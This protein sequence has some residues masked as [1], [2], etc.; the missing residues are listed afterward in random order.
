MN[1]LFP[2]HR[3]LCAAENTSHNMHNIVTLRGALVRDALGV[4]EVPERD[5]RAL[6]C[7]HRRAVRAAP[8]ADVGRRRTS[9]SSSGCSATCTGTCTTRP[10]VSSTRAG[11]A[12]RSPRRSSCPP[13]SPTRGTAGATTAASSHNVKAIAQRYLGWFDGNP[14]RLHALPPE[15][16]AVRYVEYMG[17]ADT[18]LERARVAFDDGEYRWVAQVVDHVVFADPDHTR[19]ASAAGGCA[20]AARLPDR[21]RDV[22]ELLP[23]GR[24][25]AA[26]RRA[27]P[28]RRCGRPARARSAWSR[29]ST[30]WA[31]GSTARRP[32]KAVARRQLG[33]H[34]Y[35]RA[36]RRVGRARRDQLRARPPRPARRRHDH[37]GTAPCSTGSSPARSRSPD[38]LAAGDIVA[39]RRPRGTRVVLRAHRGVDTRLPDRHA[40]SLV[41]FA[42]PAR[43]LTDARAAVGVRRLRCVS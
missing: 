21:E 26:P 43:S 1:F 13:S 39:R 16:A 24:A 35:R 4:V 23:D 28:A 11:P 27:R 12:R 10:C 18:V 3:V 2:Q 29:C 19:R 41:D 32:R 14:A 37:A 5:D 25:R 42:A 8:L 22:A 34:G 7:S 17:G 30:C 36:V 31:C 6:R 9:T 40:L 15:E 33:V 38:A 20:R